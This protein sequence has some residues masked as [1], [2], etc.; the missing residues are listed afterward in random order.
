[1]ADV[2]KT[3]ANC[4]NVQASG[5]FCE[6]CGTRMPA[7]PSYAGTAAV[8]G[9][10][11]A[12]GAAAYATTRPATP[13]PAAPPASAPQAA[14]APPY[15]PQSYGGT[16]PAQAAPQYTAA[17]GHSAPQYQATPSA[18]GGGQYGSPPPPTY[19]G[20]RYDNAKSRGFFA[21][22][23]DFSFQEFITPSIIKVLFI[24]S[25]VVIGLS[26]LGAIITGFMAGA[27]TG[28]F[29]IIGGL[30]FGFLMILYVRVLL[31]LF[32]VFFRI[33]DD[34]QEMAKKKH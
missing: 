7:S 24:I 1:V 10:A 5:E 6:K 23:F 29:T 18:Q 31:E 33:H 27:G 3:C 26:V 12:A 22:L 11:A 4:G 16:Q 2:V 32:I 17:A 25:L 15:T 9:T 28:V 21:R 30:I 8:A 13:P 34:T 20:P 14:A 19:G